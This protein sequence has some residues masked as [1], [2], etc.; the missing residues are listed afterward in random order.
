MDPTDAHMRV[1]PTECP[2][3]H[4][5]KA[6]DRE[7]KIVKPLVECHLFRGFGLG[8]AR[9]ENLSCASGPR[10]RFEVPDENVEKGGKR[11]ED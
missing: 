4:T 2:H 3:S 11:H 6:D 5:R 9:A 7:K 10:A 1:M 8:F